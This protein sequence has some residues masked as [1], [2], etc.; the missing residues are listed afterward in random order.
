ME[1]IRRHG[2]ILFHYQLASCWQRWSD[3]A[4]QRPETLPSELTT[5]IKASV[6]SDMSLLI[7]Y[8]PLL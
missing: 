6:L 8:L 3:V 2:E 1:V 4:L 7:C 5:G